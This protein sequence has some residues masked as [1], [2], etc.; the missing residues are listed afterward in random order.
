MTTKTTL[1]LLMAL[2]VAAC[3]SPATTTWTST[4]SDSQYTPAEETAQPAHTIDAIRSIGAVDYRNVPPR[5]ES[6]VSSD[7]LFAAKR[8]G[9][10]DEITQRTPGA[11]PPPTASPTVHSSKV[12]T[13]A[14]GALFGFPGISAQSIAVAAGSRNSPISGSCGDAPI[15]AAD[16]IGFSV[17]PTVCCLT[18]SF[19]NGAQI[20]AATTDALLTGSPPPVVHL[21]NIVLANGIG[22]SIQPA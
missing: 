14:D 21:A 1:G 12:G 8:R 11:Q 2:G 13:V 10:L 4:T 17:R 20:Y 18:G 22:Y 5:V 6:F 7:P 9:H 19:C 3:S 16:S 15:I